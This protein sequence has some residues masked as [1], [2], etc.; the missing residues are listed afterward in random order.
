MSSEGSVTDWIGQLQAGNSAAAQPLW[1][2]YFHQLVHLARKRLQ[3]S[4]RRAADEEDVA[5]SAFDSFCRAAEQ[6]RFPL[7][8]D[9]DDL[10]QVLVMLT[11]RKALHVIRDERRQKRGG[12]RVL[13][14][15]ALAGAAP[16]DDAG[17]DA[18]IG[19]EPTPDF[20]AQVAE[21]Y[22]RLLDLLG[23]DELRRIA[24]SRMEGYS[25]EEIAGRLGCAPRTVER[26]MR[27]IRGLW[28]TE[29]P[30]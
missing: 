24:V 13:D 22:R 2:R 29:A 6:Q 21:Q 4:P 16:G 25:T 8:A 17:L 19:A 5:L 23:D 9:R 18:V 1:E 14:E 3:G 28:S 15:N 27:R 10:W 30:S 11:A 12:G 7:L 20:A 26:K